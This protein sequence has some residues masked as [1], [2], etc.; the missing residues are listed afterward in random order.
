MG[1]LLLEVARNTL[2]IIGGMYVVAVLIAAIWG[3]RFHLRSD[4]KA[5]RWG[6]C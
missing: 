1:Q 5:D 6:G 4:P 2:T 3:S